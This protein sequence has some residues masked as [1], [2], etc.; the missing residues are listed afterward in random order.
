MM[1][2]RLLKSCATPPVSWPIAL[3]LLRLAQLLL[4]ALALV[5]LGEQLAVGGGQRRGALVDPD[6]ERV[7]QLAER[8]DQALALILDRLA[9]GDVDHRADVAEIGAVLAEPRRRDLDR[10][11]PGAVGAAQAILEAERLLA[12]IRGE[13]RVADLRPGLR[14]ARYRAAEAEAGRLALSAELVPAAAQI[15][16]AARGIGDPDHDRRMI[17]HVAEARLALAQR[18]SVWRRSASSVCAAG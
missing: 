10:P 16:A 4:D 17:G 12:G 9:L 7:G 5:D 2:S 13:E 6:L 1:V 11:A 18:A 3:H 8:L 14:D 15:G